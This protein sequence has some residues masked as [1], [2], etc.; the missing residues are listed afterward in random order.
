MAQSGFVVTSMSDDP[1]E[2]LIRAY[3]NADP[4]ATEPTSAAV[5]REIRRRESGPRFNFFFPLWEWADLVTRPRMAAA[6][7]VAIVVGL[8]P[9]WFLREPPVSTGALARD[10]LHLESFVGGKGDLLALPRSGQ[11]PS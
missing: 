4:G 9:G 10:A 7:A 5:W 2:K 11:R 6:L 3:A 1:L 8:A